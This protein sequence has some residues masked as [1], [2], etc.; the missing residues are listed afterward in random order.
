MN[1]IVGGGVIGLP[2]AASNFGEWG[3][4]CAISTVIVIA[5]TSQYFNLSAAEKLEQ[6]DPDIIPG[7]EELGFLAAGNR[8]WGK[9]AVSSIVMFHTFTCC[10][11][12]TFVIKE[13]VGPIIARIINLVRHEKN[14]TLIDLEMFRSHDGLPEEVCF[15]AS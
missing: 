8:R 11:A 1:L 5:M 15:Y 9:L 3:F 7:Y 12:Y 13:E 6:I 10:C 2:F 4:V 14:E